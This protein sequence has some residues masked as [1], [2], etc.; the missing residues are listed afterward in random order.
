MNGDALDPMLELYHGS[1]GINKTTLGHV[2]ECA[3]T[4]T[5]KHSLH[6]N[7]DNTCS[8]PLTVTPLG[9]GST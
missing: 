2:V 4:C 9:T 7:K 6:Y 5:N 1:Y 8:A 3:Y